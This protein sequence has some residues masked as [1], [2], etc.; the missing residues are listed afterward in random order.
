M[1]L[2]TA[3]CSNTKNDDI[4][5]I[6]ASFQ[7]DFSVDNSKLYGEMKVDKDGTVTFSFSGDDLVNGLTIQVKSDT[8]IIEV[9]G[10]T[11]TYSK[12]EVPVH[13]PSLYIYD[14]LISAKSLKPKAQA[15]GYIIT[16]NSQSGQFEI[17]LNSTGFIS[18]IDLKDTDYIFVFDNH[19]K[20]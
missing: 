12:K 19:I 9:N 7:C 20:S 15:D 4:T 13:S 11:E 3:G 16:G 17:V 1:I 10:V 18:K 5:P 8:V 6:L 14:S 2:L